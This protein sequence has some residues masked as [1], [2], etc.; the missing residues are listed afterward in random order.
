MRAGKKPE[1]GRQ[2]VGEVLTSSQSGSQKVQASGLTA[3]KNPEEDRHKKLRGRQA[4][5]GCKYLTRAAIYLDERAGKLAAGGGQAS[6]Q[7]ELLVAR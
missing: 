1:G 5:L 2:G 7:R 4:A 3:S 6:S